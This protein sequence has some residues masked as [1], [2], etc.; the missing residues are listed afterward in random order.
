MSYLQISTNFGKKTKTYD[1]YATIQQYVA[2]TLADLCKEHVVGSH[3][4]ILEI[5]CGTGFLSK[6]L[7]SLYPNA[8]FTFSDISPAMLAQ[9][10]TSTHEVNASAKPAYCLFNPETDYLN[11]RFDLIISSMSFQW[12]Y[13]PNHTLEKLNQL[14]KPNGNILFATIGKKSFMQWHH[15]AASLG[16]PI[17]TMK[18][19]PWPGIIK[20]EIITEHYDNALSFFR[21]LKAIGANQPNMHYQ[22]M[23]PTQLKQLCHLIDKDHYS[24]IDWHILYGKL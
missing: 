22:T 5:G 23:K 24:S 14:L 10:R 12:F 15:S 17:G 4:D 8:Q 21:S 16:L 9:C 13:E 3:L 19:Q 2:H 7:I 6:Q 18:L 20:E 1:H 11:K